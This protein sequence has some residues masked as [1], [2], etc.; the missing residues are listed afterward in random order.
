MSAP[1]RALMQDDFPL[2]LNHIRR[3]MGSCNHGAEV[4]SADTDFAR[5]TEVRWSNQLAGT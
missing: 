4:V 3:R 2:T 1:M 5:F